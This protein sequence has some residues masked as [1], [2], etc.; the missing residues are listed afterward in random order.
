M[1]QYVQP[2]KAAMCSALGSADN[3]VSFQ[4]VGGVAC[5]GWGVWKLGWGGVGS[6]GLRDGPAGGEQPAGA[7]MLHS[8]GGAQLCKNGNH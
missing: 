5:I 8:K 3:K 7:V 2:P 6:G 1:E 4:Q